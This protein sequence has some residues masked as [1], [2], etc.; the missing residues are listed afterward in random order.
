M[1]H[2]MKIHKNPYNTQII[3]ALQGQK[4]AL[5]TKGQKW[6]SIKCQIHC[7]LKES[8]GNL[9]FYVLTHSYNYPTPL[10]KCTQPNLHSDIVSGQLAPDHFKEKVGL[11]PHD[12]HYNITIIVR[13]LLDAH[14]C[15]IQAL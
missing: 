10:C 14:Y 12:R 11:T 7:T 8:E 15:A 5:N 4:K 6:R 3:K 13:Y 1:Y 2:I 9:C